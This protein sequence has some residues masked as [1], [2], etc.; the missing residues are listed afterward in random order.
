M[1]CGHSVTNFKL[2]NILSYSMD[3]PC[4]VVALVHLNIVQ[5]PHLPVFRIGAADDDLDDNLIIVWGWDAC[6]F[7]F[8]LWALSDNY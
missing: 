5:V 2:C 4:D 8:N 7:E 1:E 3:G 6:V